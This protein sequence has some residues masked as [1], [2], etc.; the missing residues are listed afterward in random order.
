MCT[1]PFTSLLVIP[2]SPLQ[3][4]G[5]SIAEESSN[6][7]EAVITTDESVSDSNFVGDK[8]QSFSEPKPKFDLYMELDL[9]DGKFYEIPR[10]S[11]EKEEE[12]IQANNFAESIRTRLESYGVLFNPYVMEEDRYFSDVRY[13]LLPIFIIH[14][15]DFD[16][17][18][19]R[20]PG[21]RSTDS[22]NL[23]I[24]EKSMFK[25]AIFDI[26]EIDL[27][28]CFRAIE[29]NIWFV[30][31]RHIGGSGMAGQVQEWHSLTNEN[32]PIELKYTNFY[33]T[34][35]YRFGHDIDFYPNLL[36]GTSEEELY[37]N[38][39]NIPVLKVKW[40]KEVYVEKELSDK[41]KFISLITE[42]Y[43][44][45]R[46]DASTDWESFDYFS[47]TDIGLLDGL[48]EQV[49]ELLKNG[50]EEE[51]HVA[52]QLVDNYITMPSS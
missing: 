47:I 4:T 18:Y 15:G 28:N 2:K 25:N 6:K 32:V 36:Y 11:K 10:L 37:I 12:F 42:G 27:T 35:N 43:D 48:E 52:Q 29:K 50:T 3:D 33:G 13:S 22:G 24:F 34:S 7:N 51:K 5:G 19:M 31:T 16:L 41:D 46:L 14:Y 44:E 17:L 1:T 39:Q 23:Y 30:V 20:Y 26:G 49:Y 21:Y 40:Q 8:A 45:H 9:E 38:E